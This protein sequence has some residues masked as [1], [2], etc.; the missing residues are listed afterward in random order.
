M[1]MVIIQS[2]YLLGD[3]HVHVHVHVYVHVHVC[4]L[5]LCIHAYKVLNAIKT[6]EER[7]RKNLQ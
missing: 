4:M 2:N 6:V 7:I 3:I 5:K 1:V